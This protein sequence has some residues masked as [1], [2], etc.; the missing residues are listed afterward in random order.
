MVDDSRTRLLMPGRFNSGD[1]AQRCGTTITVIVSDLLGQR[2]SYLFVPTT[3]LAEVRERLAASRGIEASLLI[4]VHHGTILSGDES[5]SLLA[6]GLVDG[7]TVHAF[8][9][10]LHTPIMRGAEPA[11]RNLSISRA[12]LAPS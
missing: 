5:R 7:S 9:K 11:V 12:G 1:F 10:A 8:P 6:L 2:R 4:I 3:S